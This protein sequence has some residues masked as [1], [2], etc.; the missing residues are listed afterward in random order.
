VLAMLAGVLVGYVLTIGTF[1]ALNARY[2]NMLFFLIVGT[3]LGSQTRA[4]REAR[5]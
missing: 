4:A 5:G 1:D 3:V 2:A